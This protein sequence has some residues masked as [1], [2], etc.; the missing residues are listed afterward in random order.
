MSERGKKFVCQ[1]R[2]I[3]LA[4]AG[5]KFH[6]MCSAG[7]LAAAVFGV[8]CETGEFSIDGYFI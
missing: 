1:A 8:K 7:W 3:T 5:A 4:A 6:S 2:V